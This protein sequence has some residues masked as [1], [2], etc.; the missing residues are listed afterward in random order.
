MLTPGGVV[1]L[2][3]FGLAKKSTR[4]N[5]TLTKLTKTGTVMGS[6]YYMSPEQIRGSKPDSCSDLYSVGV[7]LYELVTG[8]RPFDGDSQFAIMAA[9]MEKIPV[10][11]VA[12]DPKLPR[13]LNDAVLMS[14]A[15]EPNARFQTAE[16]FLNALSG[17]APAAQPAGRP[18]GGP[19]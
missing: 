9:H 13:L 10:P 2:M 8:K 6:L 5:L 3:D 12:L 17:V 16:A 14:V 7:S 18:R 1:K 4:H 15:K 11:P 19:G